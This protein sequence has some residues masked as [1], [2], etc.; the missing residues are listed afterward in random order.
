MPVHFHG[1]SVNIINITR[2]AI[3]FSFN[4]VPYTVAG[5][6]YL[7]GYGSPDFVAYMSSISESGPPKGRVVLNEAD[8]ATI[9]NGLTQE[10]KKRTMT[11]E[12]EP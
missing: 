8:M 10:M 2:A 6:A 12:F 4:G 1:R 7:R 11:I 9:K 3:D 5:E